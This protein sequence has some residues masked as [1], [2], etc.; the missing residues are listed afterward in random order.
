MPR[1]SAYFLGTTDVTHN[2]LSHLQVSSY[3]N[4]ARS[5]LKNNCNHYVIIYVVLDDLYFQFNI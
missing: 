3:F 5:T 2:I 4:S 1:V